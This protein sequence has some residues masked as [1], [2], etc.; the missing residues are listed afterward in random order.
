MHPV[1]R[2]LEGG[3][4]RSVGRSERVVADVLGNPDLFGVLVTGLS[5]ENA[6]LRM[7]A[8]D[9]MEKISLMHP[10][11]LWPHHDFLIEQAARSD[12]KEV[13][14]HLA[15]MLPRLKLSATER[16]LVVNIL[17]TYFADSSSIVKTCAMQALADLARQTPKLRPSI[18]A[19]LQEL[20]AIGTPAMKAR[21]RK[22]LAELK[23]E[24]PT[25]I[26]S[27]HRSTRRTL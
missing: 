17:L 18:Q 20:T 14:W 24:S 1:L 21:G 25:T 15:Q 11:Y 13:R 16:L 12:Q 8:A 5:S 7:R 22:L 6:I 23:E 10:E 26:T 3:D 4:R 19:H 27:G 9:A 2:K